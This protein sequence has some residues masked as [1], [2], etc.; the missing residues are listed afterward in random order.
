MIDL[1]GIEELKQII[2]RLNSSCDGNEVLQDD[3]LQ[4]GQCNMASGLL[5]QAIRN[6]TE[7]FNL[8]TTGKIL[9]KNKEYSLIGWLRSTFILG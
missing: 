2:L 6:L 7:A 9:K 3:K 1:K 4:C 5:P 8:T